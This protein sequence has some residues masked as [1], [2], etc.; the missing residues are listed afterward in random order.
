MDTR[1][2]NYQISKAAKRVASCEQKVN[3]AMHCSDEIFIAASLEYKRAIIRLKQLKEN[4]ND[5][6]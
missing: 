2:L 1:E 4:R 6:T 3:G 5:R